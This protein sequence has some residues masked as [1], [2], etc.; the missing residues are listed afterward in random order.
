MNWYLS[1]QRGGAQ[2]NEIPEQIVAK[3]KQ[4]INEVDDV[5]LKMIDTEEGDVT[6]IYFSS[7]IEKMT[8]QTMVTI[9]L[10]NNLKQI[11]Q[12]AQYVDPKDVQGVVKKLNAGQTLLFSTKP[13]PY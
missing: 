10:A 1:E 3:L 13:M 7:L 2:M 5:K 9:P 11:H 6:V 4:E 12:M 8:L